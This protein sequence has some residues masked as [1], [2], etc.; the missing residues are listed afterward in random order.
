[1]STCGLAKVIP[2]IAVHL[3]A[4]HAASARGKD[5]DRGFVGEFG[6]GNDVPDIIRDDVADDEVNVFGGVSPGEPALRD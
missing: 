2:G 4:G 3:E 5:F 1:V 6:D